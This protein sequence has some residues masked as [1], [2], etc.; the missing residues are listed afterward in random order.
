M[1]KH[2]K[3]WNNEP[4]DPYVEDQQKAKEFDA[5]YAQNKVSGEAKE[6]AG[7]IRPEPQGRKVWRAK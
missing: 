2:R 7:E 3:D 5:Q 1:G 6:Q 4:F